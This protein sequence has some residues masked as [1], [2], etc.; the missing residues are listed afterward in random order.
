MYSELDELDTFPTEDQTE[1]YVYSY[2]ELIRN[3]DSIGLRRYIF[4]IFPTEMRTEKYVYYDDISDDIDQDYD[5]LIN[6]VIEHNKPDCLRVVLA[7]FPHIQYNKIAMNLLATGNMALYNIV[8]DFVS[9]FDIGVSY[10]CISSRDRVKALDN[11]LESSENAS[12]LCMVEYENLSLG[13]IGYL[14]DI[15][16]VLIRHANPDDHIILEERLLELLTRNKYE[17]AKKIYKFIKS[18]PE[19]KWCDKDGNT[20]VHYLTATSF[21]KDEIKN[22]LEL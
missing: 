15:H 19:Y 10:M 3:N 21:S 14:E 4:D 9:E 11:L 5:M 17:H 6:A 20:F 8:N 2:S 1:E 16:E 22:I 13:V 12:S 7:N 18:H